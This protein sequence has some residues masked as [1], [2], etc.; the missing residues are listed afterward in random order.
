MGSGEGEEIVI[1]PIKGEGEIG[2][3]NVYFQEKPS[4]I[5]P[6]WG[7]DEDKGGNPGPML[8]IKKA[9][10]LFS[11]LYKI[12]FIKLFSLFSLYYF[13]R[14]WAPLARP[15]AHFTSRS[16]WQFRQAKSRVTK[17]FAN[18]PS[19]VN[20]LAPASMLIRKR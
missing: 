15:A 18:L 17:F 7:I 14:L 9:G 10:F 16:L 3:V 5:L 6:S 2:N 13:P 1:F 20:M 4:F 11:R 8:Y 19:S 12:V